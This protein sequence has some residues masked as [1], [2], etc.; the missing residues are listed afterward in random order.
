MKKIGLFFPDDFGVKEPRRSENVFAKKQYTSI[1]ARVS[2]GLS[3][4]RKYM[5]GLER[6]THLPQFRRLA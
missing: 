4:M 3:C 5:A 6:Q 1:V 2:H